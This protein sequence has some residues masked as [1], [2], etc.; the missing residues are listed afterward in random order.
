MMLGEELLRGKGNM[1][2]KIVNREELVKRKKV[3]I[4]INIV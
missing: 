4:D 2:L 1:I 3:N